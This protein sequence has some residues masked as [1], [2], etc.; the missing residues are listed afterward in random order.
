MK[1]DT[2]IAR[3]HVPSTVFSG[4]KFAEFSKS[5][6]NKILLKEGV[7]NADKDCAISDFPEE[8]E[9]KLKKFNSAIQEYQLSSEEITILNICSEYGINLELNC[10]KDIGGVNI[11][12]INVSTAVS[13]CLGR[14]TPET[15]TIQSVKHA[16]KEIKDELSKETFLE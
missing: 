13:G 3:A 5:F 6:D 11:R 1:N 4:E 8:V 7:K 15:I 2:I 16:I 14:Y 12:Y 10:C 9:E